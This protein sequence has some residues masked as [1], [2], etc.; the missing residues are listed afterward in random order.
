MD[1]ADKLEKIP[2]LS[3]EIMENCNLIEAVYASEAPKGD[4][5]WQF[6]LWLE[7]QMEEKRKVYYHQYVHSGKGY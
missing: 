7:S 3:Q 4:V 6:F 2:L 1:W 5:K